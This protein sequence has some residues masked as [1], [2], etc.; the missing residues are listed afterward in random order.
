MEKKTT[1]TEKRLDQFD[2]TVSI[3]QSFPIEVFPTPIL[4]FATAGQK[5]VC[6]PM[7]FFG[8]ALLA[9]V[10]IIIGNGK[11]V[12]IKKGWEEGCNAYIAIIGEPGSRKTPPLSLSLKPIFEIQTM[13]K[14][15]FKNGSESGEEK[16]QVIRLPQIITSDTT[17]EA[18]A[19][20]LNDNPHGI[21]I[22]KD[23]LIGWIKSMNQYRGGS[24]EDMEKFLTMWSQTQTIINR[25]SLK[26]PYQIDKP[27]ITIIGGIQNDL[28]LDLS[29]LK[30]N[31][32]IDRILFCFPDTVPFVHTRDEI[33]DEVMIAYMKFM[34][35]LYEAQEDISNEEKEIPIPFS[36]PA[37]GVWENWHIEHCEEMNNSELPYYLKG[38]WAKLE[39]YC[40]RFC[41][42]L[43]V[44]SCHYNNSKPNEISF[45]SITNSI[46][47]INYF[48]SH[49]RKVYDHMNSSDMDKKIEKAYQ[50]VRKQ[51]GTVNA[52]KFYSYKVAGCKNFHDAMDFF[53]EMQD[54]GMGLIY[55]IPN[56]SGKKK[57]IFR[58]K[59]ISANTPNQK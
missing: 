36:I 2:P 19:Q 39:A 43:E 50:W 4:N 14:K 5:S 35:T 16:N 47:L 34:T 31:G 32:L 33:S 45:E 12:R 53:A 8:G 40:A 21:I 7:D 55:E 1:Q 17:I 52:R 24:G 37:Y 59:S 44:L 41:L 51:G 42:I 3:A 54:R 11:H 48:K 6:C 58:L 30:N 49:A 22:F 29:G 27:F 20:L 26:E 56:A 18:L 15:A 28:L 9:C 23:E 25:K 46:K 38:A 10:S 57:I 13:F